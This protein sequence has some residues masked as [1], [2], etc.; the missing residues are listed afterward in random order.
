MIAFNLVIVVVIVHFNAGVNEVHDQ[1][2]DFGWQ[3]SAQ[4]VDVIIDSRNE[5]DA[6]SSPHLTHDNVSRI[7]SFDNV[8]QT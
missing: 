5:N 7:L 8:Q 2:L 6:G 4:I 3:E 1:P